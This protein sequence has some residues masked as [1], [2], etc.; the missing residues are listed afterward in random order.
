ML[1]RSDARNKTRRFKP[2]KAGRRN[3]SSRVASPDFGIRNPML[4]GLL[5]KV[6]AAVERHMQEAAEGGGSNPGGSN[7]GPQP[8]AAGAELRDAA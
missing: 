2:A 8:G 6:Q 3:T 4:V 7:P 5:R 1:S